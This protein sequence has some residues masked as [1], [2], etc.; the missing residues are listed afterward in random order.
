MSAR[1]TPP[2]VDEGDPRGLAA[3]LH[4][5]LRPTP[6]RF[7]DSLRIVVVLL[8]VVTIAEI[9]RIPDSAISAYLVL[10]LSGREA[11]STVLT[12]LISGIA[13]VLALVTT[14]GVF[15]VSLAEPALRIP[16][17]AALTFCTMFLSRASPFGPVFAE[18]GKR[19]ILQ[20][21]PYTMLNPA[22][23]DNWKDIEI[24]FSPRDMF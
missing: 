8:I 6:G 5:E 4:R 11:V 16:L 20:C 10:F 14:I 19:A 3:L 18:S 22:H 17:M 7:G 1:A 2:D 23:Y 13:A 24:E 12:A 15:M 9:F 21:Q